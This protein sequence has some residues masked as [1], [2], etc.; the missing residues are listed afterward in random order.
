VEFEK[1]FEKMEGHY[2][3]LNDGRRTIDEIRRAMPKEDF[4]I[5]NLP[6]GIRKALGTEAES[7]MFSPDSLAKQFYKHSEIT[8]EEYRS[9]INKL[10]NS[11]ECHETR[12]YHIAVIVKSGRHRYAAILKTTQNLKGAYLVSLHR[13]NKD[14][15]D[16][17]RKG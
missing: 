1:W 11:N 7:L 2:N 12:K 17:I 5:D 9:V 16:K 4:V 6:N 15:L 14:T 8:L 13:L 10:K 3:L